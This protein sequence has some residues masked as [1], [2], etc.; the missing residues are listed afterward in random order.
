MMNPGKYMNIIHIVVLVVL[1]SLQTTLGQ[2]GSIAIQPDDKII[3]FFEVYDADVRSV[4]KQL[5]EYSGVDIVA[6]EN[7][8]GSVTISVTKKSWSE[9]L[10]II[11]K[12]NNLAP[13]NEGNYVYVLTLEEFLKRQTA[14][15]T[16][17]DAA[18]NLAPLRREIIKINHTPVNEIKES[19]NGLLSARGKLTTVEHNNSI[20]VYDTDQNIE[21]IQKMITAF[22]I[23]TAQISISCKIIEASTGSQQNLGIQWG[24]MSHAAGIQG[25]HLANSTNVVAG[26][27]EKV[28]YGILNSDNLTATLEYLFADGKAEVVAQP[29]ITTLDNKEARI[30]MGQKI[31]FTNLDEAGNT[32]VTFLDAGTELIVKPHLSGNGRILL[33][34]KPT[35]A[36]YELKGNSYVVNQQGAETNVVVNNGETVVI[37]GLTSDEKLKSEEGIPFLKNLPFIGHLFKRSSKSNSKKDLMI[38]VTPHIVQKDFSDTQATPP[39]SSN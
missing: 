13:S 10:N 24:Y 3:E 2:I 35:K 1:L 28:S 12:V 15:A 8:K 18:I 36:S 27:L 20:I 26:A 37:A 22:D 7:V 4:F 6:A 34:L 14:Q 9:I 5:S 31:P 19:V 30:F 32:V 23:E 21:Q 29:Q 33:E 16:S 38:F 17:L 25:Q 11:C 39:A